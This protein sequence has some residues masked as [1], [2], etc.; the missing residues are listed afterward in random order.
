M[1]VNRKNGPMY[2]QIK[3]ILKDRILHGVYAIDTNIP[4]EPLLEEEF[5][6]SKV[7]VRNAIKELVQE[8]YVEK[9]SGKGTRVI[10]NGSIVKLSKGKRFT[11]LLVEEGHSILKKVLNISRID[12]SSD[13]K[14]HSL[15]GA[16]C[17]SIERIYL[18]D[19]EPYIYFTH[20]IS[21]DLNKEEI[22]DVQINSL[23]RFLEEQNVKLETFRDEFAVAI[24]PDHI[25][26]TLKIEYNSPVLKRIR[27]SSDGDGN[28]TEYSEGYYNTAKQNYIVTYNEPVQ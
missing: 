27:I 18:L 5:N 25:C 22:K 6:V 4:S 11:E 15:F 21:L 17:I 10:A 24:A 3:E 8:G 12:L 7:T 20:Y 23:Y 14:L 2:L 19:N 16:R 28:V 13:S 26:E 1:N 9:K